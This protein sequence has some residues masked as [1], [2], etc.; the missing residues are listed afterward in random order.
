VDEAA[1]KTGRCLRK[2]DSCRQT[3]E[4][5]NVGLDDVDV[6]IVEVD[7]SL[8]SIAILEALNYSK[9]APPAI[10]LIEVDE[11]EATH[12]VQRHGAAACLKK[13]FGADELATLINKV[14]GSAWQKKS[15]SCDK[16]GH[17]CAPRI[18]NS[19]PDLTPVLT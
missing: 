6:V 7:A 17:V 14:C 19:R 18:L 8:H 5:L 11:A 10:A 13:P 2:A 15:L 4:V 3:F 12:I 9:A 1:G 16:W